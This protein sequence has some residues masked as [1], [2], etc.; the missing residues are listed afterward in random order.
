MK[1]ERIL[2]AC[3][4]VALGT[5][6]AVSTPVH[7]AR[8]MLVLIDASGSMFNS[9]T[10]GDGTRFEAARSLA[11]TRVLQQ[12]QVDSGILVAVYTFNGPYGPTTLIPRT[13][14]F[15][16]S[17]SA[18]DAIEGLTLSV[19]GGDTPLAGS[20]CD[21]IDLLNSASSQGDTKIL[22]L[23]S[24]GEENSTPLDHLCHGPF[25][26]DGFEPFDA[27]SWQ[28]NVL[29]H[30]GDMIVR[31][32]LFDSRQITFFANEHGAILTPQARSFAT[33]ISPST[34]LTPLQHFFTVLAQSTGG[35]LTIIY[36]DEPLP[37]SGDLNDDDCVDYDD[38]IL[39]ARAFGPAVPPVDGRFDLNQDRTV[40]FADYQ[41]QLSR[42]TP[43]CGP[44]P[45][46]SRAPLVCERATQIL[47]DGQSIEDSGNGITIDARGACK[48]TIR[49]SLIVS[50]HNGI[51]ILGNAV[52]SVDN[53]IIV[54]QNAAIVQH[55]RGVLSAR[56]TVF[57]GNTDFQGPSH[58][59][60][61][62]GNVFE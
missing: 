31:I 10:N 61:R 18:L 35:Q 24:D 27:G 46:V 3:I 23:S 19:V 56:D 8:R 6:M 11:I 22:Q 4:A 40:D 49:N 45:Y 26:Q 43:T 51:T 34:G 60:D 53:S 5:I 41:I 16:D 21:A 47:I 37:V 12:A 25:D 2:L 59:I 1:N 39:V 58:F 7:A 9:R 32:D 48:I 33:T 52:V 28:Q 17:N 50:G 54:G 20:L 13:T 29:D 57:H 38:A 62:G 44:N 36:D 15:V 55:G 30:L 14:G 42:I